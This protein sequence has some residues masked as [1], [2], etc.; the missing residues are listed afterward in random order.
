[1]K[2]HLRIKKFCGLSPNAVTIRLWV[3]PS[4]YLLLAML[5]KRLEMG[6]SLYCISQIPSLALFEKVQL[7]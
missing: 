4:V 3:A 6:L 1:M 2:Q 7:L 5:R